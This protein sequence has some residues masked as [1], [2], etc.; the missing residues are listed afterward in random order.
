[1]ALHLGHEVAHLVQVAVRLTHVLA[2]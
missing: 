2:S 1:V